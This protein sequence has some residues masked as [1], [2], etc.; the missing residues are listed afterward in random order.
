MK[1]KIL[2]VDDEP[3]NIEILKDWLEMRNYAIEVA[4]DGD[5]VLTKAAGSLP[6]L[7]LMDIT[8]KRMDGHSAVRKLQNDKRTC[9]IPIIMLTGK[10][11]GS[12][13]EE[14]NRNRVADYVI[15]PFDPAVLADKIK[16]VLSAKGR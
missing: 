16:K 10:S 8:M 9:Q 5:E 2:I 1:K 3:Q 7:I 15:K 13:L 12:D 11:D 6:D 14:A 4:Y